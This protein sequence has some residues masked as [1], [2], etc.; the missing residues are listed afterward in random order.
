M[1]TRRISRQTKFV[2]VSGGVCSGLGKGI[3][4]ASC[5]LLLR[6]MGYSV[7]AIKLDP[8]LN[9]DPG[10]MNP[11][12]HGEVF[13]TEDG[14]ET[15]LDLGHYERFLD[16][17]LSK[18]SSVSAGQIFS[19][20]I[21]AERHGK[22]LG[23]TVQ[24]IPHITDEIKQ[25]ILRGAIDAQADIVLVEIGGTVGDMEGE[26]F[27]EAVRQ[28][29]KELGHGRV[30]HIFLGFLPY[31]HASK[32]LKTKPF[33]NAI[34]TLRH[35]GIEPDILVA[36]SDRQIPISVL[37]KIALFANTG[38]DSVI[39]AATRNDS[40]YAVPLGYEE[41]GLSKLLCTILGLKWKVPELDRWRAF[42]MKTIKPMTQALHIAI[43]GKYTK[44]EDSYYSVLES[45]KIAATAVGSKVII[46]WIDTE[47]I[48]NE[49]ETGEEWKK[50]TASDGVIIPGGFGKRGVEGMI[51]VARYC[52]TNKVPFFGLCLGSQIM[53]IELA[54]SFISTEADSE[55]FSPDTP[56]PVVHLM[57]S[58]Q[59]IAD[60]GGTMRLGV[61]PCVIKPKTLAAKAYGSTRVVYERHRHRFE[62]NLKYKT[63]LENAGWIA[64]GYSPDKKLIEIIEIKNHPFMLGTQFHPEFLSRPERPHPLFLAF[65][66][67]VAR[68][69]KLR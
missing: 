60:K 5:G 26:A 10:T 13:V 63:Q 57:Q 50:L 4:A 61:F 6:K 32:E 19:K 62:F 54:R 2:F 31:L 69:S 12:E 35:A 34:R 37:E 33:Q 29:T 59:E 67:K 7:F 55:E 38:L 22:F 53:S 14:A 11:A 17:P 28:L 65:M 52:R 16:V 42:V 51:K 46:E 3:T 1:H 23:K 48:E 45:I 21:G 47:K 25:S 36:R 18:N 64:S 58:Q 40:V 24:L 9:V 43:A 30:C 68:I 49:S 27:F 41:N 56:F 8:Y 20:V 66:R 44:L 39:P 15:D